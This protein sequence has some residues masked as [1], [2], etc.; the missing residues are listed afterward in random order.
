MAPRALAEVA[1]KLT[2]ADE[3]TWTNMFDDLGP[4]EM[5]RIQIAFTVRL[6]VH[7]T[8]RL[9]NVLTSVVR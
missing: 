6:L 9:I 5:T 8:S 7:N 2:A 1:T 3:S 4:A